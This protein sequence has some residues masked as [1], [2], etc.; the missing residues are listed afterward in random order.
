MYN[1]SGDY[2][3]NDTELILN[4]LQMGAPAKRKQR[5]MKPIFDS[6]FLGPDPIFKPTKRAS[7]ATPKKRERTIQDW[8][9]VD[10][11]RYFWQSLSNFGIDPEINPRRDSDW[12][13]K[14]YDKFVDEIGGSMTNYILRDYIDWWIGTY[15]VSKSS[16]PM[17]IFSLM[18]DSDIAKF[19]SQYSRRPMGTPKSAIKIE[20][21]VSPEELYKMSGISLVLMGHGIVEAYRVLTAN[22]LNNVYAQLS[23]VLKSYSKEVLAKVLDIT[24]ANRYNKE[25]VVDFIS[26]ARPAL[27]FHG[28]EKKY[29]NID[30]THYFMEA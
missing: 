19:L 28:I 4:A 10:F 1:G 13:K 9:S 20:V 12:T 5:R 25:D 8:K 29:D 27:K 16:K 11:V 17:G 21:D 22:G 26:V 24:V 15:A 30:Y 3:V 2:K 7:R 6:G 18:R 14:L 23:D